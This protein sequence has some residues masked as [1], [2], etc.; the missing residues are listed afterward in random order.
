MKIPFTK[1]HGTGNDF[2]LIDEFQKI[3]VPEG[4]K[5]GFV[6][7]ISR[8]HYGVGSDGVIFIQKSGRYD[9][10]FL[11]YNPD[12]SRAEM[13]G[14]GMMCF[15]KYLYEK[16]LVRKKVIRVETLAGLVVSEILLEEWEVR[17]VKV[18]MGTPQVEFVDREVE[19][20]GRYRITSV[21][22]GNPHAVL[23]FKEVD[24]VDVGDIGKKVRHYKKLFPQ[25]TNVHFIQKNRGNEFKIR[26][27]ERGVEKET[28]ACGT[29]VSASAVAAVINNLADA[30]KPLRF[31]AR[32]GDLITELEIEKGDVKK[33]FLTGPADEVFTGEVELQP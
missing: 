33:V 31:H 14:N 15:A 21:N 11:F 5:P 23:F 26:T 3:L 32:G 22:I 8:R 29:G 28:L 9:A 12:G 27:Y 1:M 24:E 25:G 7:R 10:K 30:R 20:K 6:A 17:R 16:G 4:D 19:I 18:D 2:I 13:C